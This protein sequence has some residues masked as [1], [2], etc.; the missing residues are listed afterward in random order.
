MGMT[1]SEILAVVKNIKSTTPVLNDRDQKLAIC[2]YAAGFPVS[3]IAAYLKVDRY[4]IYPFLK[5][6]Q[7]I[8]GALMIEL[9]ETFIPVFM[10][11]IFEAMERN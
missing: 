11:D 3:N 7:A 4:R 9:C 2:L 6:Y 10:S 1:R 5:P 8:Q